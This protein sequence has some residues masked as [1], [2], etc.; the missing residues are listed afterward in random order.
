M[1]SAFNRF[2]YDCIS[3][4]TLNKKF[5]DID[6]L[7]FVVESIERESINIVIQRDFSAK[8]HKQ[9]MIYKV[10]KLCVFLVCCAVF[11]YGLPSPVSY[12]PRINSKLANV[13]DFHFDPFGETMHDR[14]HCETGRIVKRSISL[15]DYAHNLNYVQGYNPQPAHAQ[16]R[17]G[18]EIADTVEIRK[19]SFPF[20]YA[21]RIG[22]YTFS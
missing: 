7:V 22:D 1:A 9:K 10:P 18:P 13:T 8:K 5:L 3:R 4:S 15:D 20:I 19:Y 2:Q 6:F 16:R 14:N 12:V 17:G 21:A 11:I